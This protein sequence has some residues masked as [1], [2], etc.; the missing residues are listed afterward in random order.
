MGIRHETSSPYSPHQNGTAER[1]WRTLFEMGRCLLIDKGLPKFLW[2]YAVQTAA[3]I[4]NRCFNN[5]I[6][7]TPYHMLTGNQPDLSKMGIFGSECYAY[8]HDPKKLDS[9]CEKGIFVGYDKNSPAYLVYHANSGKV[10][11]NRLVKFCKKRGIEKQTQTDVLDD[12]VE[13]FPQ[14]YTCGESSGDVMFLKTI[15]EVR[16]MCLKE[17]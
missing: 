8:K 12:E 6:K 7:Q 16:Q 17:K 11:K 10:S 1:Q 9:R 4:R 3:H 14:Q 2:T 15:M 13:L 5:R